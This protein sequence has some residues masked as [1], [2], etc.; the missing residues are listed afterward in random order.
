MKLTLTLIISFF[1]FIIVSKAQN[2]N[3]QKDKF[4]KER[5]SET[6]INNN[7]ESITFS[8]NL[9]S[10]SPKYGNTPDVQWFHEF[11]GSAYDYIKD[12]TSDSNGN[13]YVTGS[14]SGKL[15]VG[16][17]NYDAVGK[18]DAFVAKIDMNGKFI[19]FRQLSPKEK[20]TCVTYSIT[21][22]NNDDIYITGYYTGDISIGAKNLPNNNGRSLF[23]THISNDG[24]IINSN[25]HNKSDNETGLYIK[26]DHNSNVY[27][28][29]TTHT[30]T[31][32]RHSSWV[33]KYNNSH[34]LVSEL[35][36]EVG[37]NDFVIHDQSIFYTGAILNGNNG[38]LNNNIVITD[39][40]GYYDV[41]VA[42]SNLDM[43]FEWSISPSR[44]Q[45]YNGYSI[46]SE[47]G[48]D[49][50][51]NLY[52]TGSYGGNLTLGEFTVTNDNYISISFITK[53]NGDGNIEWLQ[54]VE[55]DS[56]SIAVDNNYLYV[57]TD[58]ENIHMYQLDGRLNW[59]RTLKNSFN[60]LCLSVSF[61]FFSLT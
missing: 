6:D 17:S 9:Q 52:V 33:L 15:K 20:M 27:I 3:I 40:T 57:S 23:Y 34:Q 24:D 1:A 11:G 29:S 28:T 12:I 45:N 47:I 31:D 42:K 22:D 35:F 53:I 14:F 36:T 18:R 46:N 41:F 37:L 5:I 4:I 50:S 43:Q 55:G 7:T 61:P 13:K 51:G 60:N 49:D 44:D 25:Y 30:S 39:P 58:N 16:E 32:S 56:K 2:Q 21:L 8:K 19:W 38:L 26:T 48:I 10:S 59:N 54:N